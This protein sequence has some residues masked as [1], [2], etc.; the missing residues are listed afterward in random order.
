MGNRESMASNMKGTQFQ[1]GVYDISQYT[2]IS[3]S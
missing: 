2:M 3:F 1:Q